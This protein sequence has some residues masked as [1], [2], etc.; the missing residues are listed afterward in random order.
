MSKENTAKGNLI[1]ETNLKKLR[2]IL[3]EQRILTKSQ[4][5]ELSG[6]S[7]VTIQSLIK[8]LLDNGEITEDAIV[9]PQLGRPA[10]TFR[11]NANHRL[12]LTV[13]MYEADGQDTAEY[14]VYNLCGEVLDRHLEQLPTVT[15]ESFHGAIDGLIS[16]YPAI[17]VIGFGMPAEE[18]EGRLVISDYELLK[19]TE[20][21][22]YYEAR[23][24][25]PVFVENDINAAL[26]GYCVNQHYP[27]G[28][29]F[30]TAAIYLPTKYPA[31]ASLCHNYQ[32][33]KGRNGLAGELKYLPLD[34]DW[35]AFPYPPKALEDIALK[36]MQ[37]IISIYNPDR[38]ILYS[39]SLTPVIGERLKALYPTTTDKILIP[40]IEL[41]QSMD[42]DLGVGLLQMALERIDNEKNTV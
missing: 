13:N 11:Y 36:V 26:L 16:S 15:L 7:V 42:E 18:I 9:Q 1:K 22:A 33:L 12:A 40:E 17:S 2:Q 14:T 41:Y 3:R 28:Q 39:E 19:N 5:A 25:I 10:A 32:I 38:I 34:I 37:V 24:H 30:Y 27:A 20:L 35:T 23:C 21:A 31:G 4:L 6:L 8:T 29:D